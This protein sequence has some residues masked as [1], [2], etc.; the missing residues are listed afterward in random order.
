MD[1][2]ART[3][4]RSTQ[5]V[6]NL[7]HLEHVNILQ[8][9]QRPTTLFYVVALGG[10]RDPYIFVGLDNMWVNYGRTQIHMPSRDPQP[11]VIRGTMGFVVPD[12]EAV[13]ARMKRVSAGLAG[14]R[15]SWKDAGET[16]EATC[17]WGNRVRCH[18]PSPDLGEGTELGIVYVEFDV[19]PGT[20]DGIARFYSEIMGA[21]SKVI[22]RSGAPSAHV[23][24]GR[25][26][27]LYFTETDQPIPAYDGHHIEIYIGDFSG[28]YRKLAERGLISMETDAYEW[29]FQKIVDPATN[30]LLFEIEHEIRS[31]RHP[32]YAR[33][34]VNRNPLQTNTKYLRNQDEFRGSY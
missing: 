17:P 25:G 5:D 9:D 28:P 26:Q 29:R 4:D 21:P 2:K 24:V 1:M 20:A 11:Q 22:Q 19:A 12:L 32:L 6:S 3:F 31:L 23:P 15:F 30:K 8:P 14:T 18:S 7:V 10:T 13:K 34:L 33:P 16:V 27:A